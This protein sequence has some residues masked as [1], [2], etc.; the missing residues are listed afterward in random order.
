M[1]IPQRQKLPTELQNETDDVGLAA[2]AAAAQGVVDVV[3][4]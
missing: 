1:K 2:A 4:L 3:I